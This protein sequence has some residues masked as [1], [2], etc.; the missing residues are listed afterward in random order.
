MREKPQTAKHP[1]IR[2]LQ[3]AAGQLE[4][5]GI[6]SSNYRYPAETD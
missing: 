6:T 3:P 2:S 1:Q 5:P 4:C